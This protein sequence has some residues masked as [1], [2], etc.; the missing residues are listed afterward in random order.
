MSDFLQDL[1]SLQGSL[2]NAQIEELNEAIFLISS[3]PDANIDKLE[4]LRGLGNTVHLRWAKAVV[5]RDVWL[6]KYQEL[7]KSLSFLTV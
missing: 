7:S 4:I 3:D 6:D 1:E 5:A 2:E